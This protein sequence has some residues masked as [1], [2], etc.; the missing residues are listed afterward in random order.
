[1]IQSHKITLFNLVPFDHKGIPTIQD[2]VDEI[3]T[4]KSNFIQ[5]WRLRWLE[6]KVNRSLEI[7]TLSSSRPADLL[8]YFT[9]LRQMGIFH[10]ISGHSEQFWNI[11]AVTVWNWKYSSLLF[12]FVPYIWWGPVTVVPPSAWQGAEGWRS[13]KV[14]L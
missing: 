4:E 5:D 8:T 11:V 12:Q 13:F 7:R 6:S 2:S 1:M 9:I 10:F 14:N 3:K